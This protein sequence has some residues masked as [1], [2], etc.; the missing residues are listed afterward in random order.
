M[1]TN[2][3]NATSNRDSKKLRFGIMCTGDRLPAAFAKCVE[4]LL[5]VPGVEL[6]LL[7]VDDTEALRTSRGQKI[8]KVLTLDGT[9]W[10]LAKRLSPLEK[11]PCYRPLDMSKIF[12]GVPRIRCSPIRKGKFSQYFSPEDVAAIQSYELD[13][14]L[15]FAFGIIRGEILT[16][17]RYGVWS[18]H[19]GDETKFRGAPPAFW[20][21]YRNDPVT[22]AILQRLTDRLDGGVVLQRAYIR[23]RPY[24]HGSN[25]DAILWATSHMPARVCRDIQNGVA[26]YLDA[27]PSRTD[28][29]IYYTP[30]DFQMAK[31]LLK[32]GTSWMWN[33]L[34]CIFMS[35]QW[36]I[37]LVQMPIHAFLDPNFEPEIRWLGYKKGGN[38]IADPFI[39][40]ID[41][42][43]ALLAEEFDGKTGRGSIV[44]ITLDNAQIA[45]PTF[46]TAI[47]EGI[48][49]S[50][51][52]IFEHQGSIYCTPESYQ[53][54]GVCLY[55]LDVNSRKWEQQ[56]WLIRN[57][58]AVDPTPF[59]Y[60]GCW[61]MFCTNQKSEVESQLYLW[62]APCLEGPWQAHPANP[63]KCD[64][65]SSR[66]AGRPFVF[67]GALYR[68]AQDTSRGYG[69]AL[70]INRI[71]RLTTHTFEEIP[72]THILPFHGRYKKGVHTLVGFGGVTVLD[73]KRYLWASGFALHR[74]IGKI[75]RLYKVLSGESARFKSTVP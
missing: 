46:R 73:G 5:A 42:S 71:T 8:K 64:V 32:T 38:Y 47:D 15:R 27:S 17:A 56:G 36:N 75:C 30:N 43:L 74:A 41:G 45:N 55:R 18:F 39:A 21:I 54:N 24:S 1:T 62:H 68:P 65:R 33:Q 59:E 20:E 49:M 28:A 22:G 61:W 72:V 48:H 52:Y 10:A 34:R 37:G 44:E 60:N 63:V 57:F 58:S 14:I 7:I 16:S 25:L 31:F 19:H 70:A 40:D 11:L 35:A 29:P 12:T 3:F 2:P 26:Q 50:Y 23:T 6:A 4:E 53:K 69:S 9:L 13:F 67:Q 66:P 51:P